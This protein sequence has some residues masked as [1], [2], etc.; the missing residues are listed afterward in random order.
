[1]NQ[2]SL[3]Y[4]INRLAGLLLLEVALFVKQK[5]AGQSEYRHERFAGKSS[6]GPNNA[7]YGSRRSRQVQA[8]EQSQHARRKYLLRIAQLPKIRE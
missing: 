2:R 8:P 5:I 6:G 1:M 4:L 3:G 7:E